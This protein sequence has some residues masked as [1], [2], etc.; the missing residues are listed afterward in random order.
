[1][2]ECREE[3]MDTYVECLQQ[4]RERLK[5][6]KNIKLIEAEHYDWSKIV[7]SVKKS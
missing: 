4:A 2:D 7:L 3:I 5:Q 6:L 1:M